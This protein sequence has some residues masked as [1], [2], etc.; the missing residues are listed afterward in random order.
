MTPSPFFDESSSRQFN[1]ACYQGRS[2]E[3]L[4]LLS[5]GADPAWTG[6]SGKTALHF[7]SM[8]GSGPL[9]GYL[10]E[11]HPECLGARDH[12]GMTPLHLACRNSKLEAALALRRAGATLDARD[13][14]GR[15][16]LEC[17]S[18]PALRDEL[19]RLDASINLGEFASPEAPGA[20]DLSRSFF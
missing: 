4:D 6:E 20:F 15:M 8:G 11:R 7:A 10:A 1:Q 13:D 17:C 5:R 3:A 2:S 19:E 14:F 12:A 16:P 18:D 9:C